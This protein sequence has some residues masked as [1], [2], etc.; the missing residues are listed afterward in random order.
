M[1]LGGHMRMREIECVHT[2]MIALATAAISLRQ[3]GRFRG[4]FVPVSRSQA[5]DDVHPLV[6]DV[7]LR[8]NPAREQTEGR[9]GVEKA[10]DQTV[11]D[12]SFAYMRLVSTI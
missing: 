5:A 8:Q 3:Q 1:I 11:W 7:V 6:G 10:H 12:P 9:D 4:G 2:W